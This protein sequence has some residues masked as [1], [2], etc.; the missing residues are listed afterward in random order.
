MSRRDTACRC[1]STRTTTNCSTCSTARLIVSG[2]GGET[3]VATNACVKLPRGLPH[4][5][6]NASA[7]CSVLVVLTPGVQALEMFRHFDRAGRAAP[8]APEDIVAIATQYG[9]TFA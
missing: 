1:T 6:R 3:V 8:L 9:V 7:A 5:F 2:T 4:A